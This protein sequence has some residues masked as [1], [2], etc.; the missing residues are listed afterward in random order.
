MSAA[1]AAPA[2]IADRPMELMERS[3]AYARGVLRTV[4]GHAPQEPTP[5]RDWDL[6]D[7]LSHLVDGLTAFAQ[8][9]AGVVPAEPRTALPRDPALLAGHL[10]DLGCGVLGG[11]LENDDECLLG[12]LPLPADVLLEA[13]ALE[14][15]VHG[16]DVAQ[17]CAPHRD[18]PP[19]LAAALL[20]AAL[21]HVSPADRPHRF[22]A[23][24]PV[25]RR[26]PA[27]LLLAHCGRTAG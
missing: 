26:D 10:L 19:A 24:R 25:A 11:W 7:L 14:I 1:S 6:A 5:C 12:L 8:A 2:A 21:R 18:L 3:I 22:D 13:A 17:V 16:W 23:V 9:A 4:P 20:P 15:A 27:A